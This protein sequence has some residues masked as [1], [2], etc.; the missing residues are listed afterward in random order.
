[1]R[2]GRDGLVDQRNDCLLECK[3]FLVSS[4]VGTYLLSAA[5]DTLLSSSIM[6]HFHTSFVAQNNIT[7][8]LAAIQLST[9][10]NHFTVHSRISHT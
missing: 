4:K 7:I 1:M 2:E 5:C 9:K 10:N 6:T 8:G 3:I